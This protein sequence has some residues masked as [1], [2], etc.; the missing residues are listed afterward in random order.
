M[1]ILQLYLRAVSNQERV[2][3]G[4]V[5][6]YS[7]WAVKAEQHAQYT[8]FLPQ[9]SQEGNEWNTTLWK[10]KAYGPNIYSYCGTAVFPI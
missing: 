7:L 9:T 2:I 10:L 3:I 8:W 5:W 1:K 4:S 6:Y